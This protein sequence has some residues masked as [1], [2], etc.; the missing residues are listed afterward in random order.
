MKIEVRYFSRTG[1][2]K[3]LAEAIAA[4]VGVEAT[5]VSVPMYE[6]ADLVFLG[7]SVYAAGVDS[8]VRNFMEDNNHRIGKLVNFST[9]AL[10]SSTYRQVKQIAEINDIDV[11]EE[12]FHCRGSF[13]FLHRGHPNEEDLAAAADFA[14][15]VV[16]QL[17][18]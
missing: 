8:A 3:Q 5:E 12:E 15:A 13:A 10:L 7:S 6:K 18:P 17:R 2:T 14:R 16:E 1:N 9:A 4:A 11:A